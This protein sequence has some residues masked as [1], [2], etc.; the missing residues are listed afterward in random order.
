MAGID[1]QLLDFIKKSNLSRYQISKLCGVSQGILSRF[2]N[3]TRDI[4]LET[5]AR[6][7]KVLKVKLVQDEQ[8]K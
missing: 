3:G 5:A 8:E 7:A 6:I 2:V 4:T 1:R